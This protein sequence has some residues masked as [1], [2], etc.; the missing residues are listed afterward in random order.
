MNTTE[1]E[2]LAS[3]LELAARIVR[4]GLEWEKALRFT[5]KEWVPAAVGDLPHHRIAAG[6]E[7]RIKPLDFARPP[8]E[9]TLH[10][11]QNL[12]SDQ[13][14]KGY[15]L[16]LPEEVDGRHNEICEMW[17]ISRG[18]WSSFCHGADYKF[19]YRL[20]LSV[21]WP[22]RTPKPDPNAGFEKWWADESPSW[23]AA[24]QSLRET[25]RTLAERAYAAG[26]EDK[27]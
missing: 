15:R 2:H 18:D 10:N 19:T 24:Q 25:F 23:D 7:I 5:E 21:P 27:L 9:A 4:E 8:Y 17:L 1:T 14:V 3:Q 12:T 20:P 13:V 11:P 22:D 26:K 16:M 6:Y